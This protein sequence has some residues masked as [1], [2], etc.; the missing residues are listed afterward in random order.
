MRL[1]VS[2]RSVDEVSAALVGGA[3]VIDVKEPLRGALGAADPEVVKAIAAKVPSSIPVSVALG[4]PADAAV[5]QATVTRLAPHREAGEVILKLGFAGATTEI[6]T[7]KRL[8][9]AID[10]AS[11]G[12][13]PTLVAVAYADWQ[14]AGGPSP[15][16]VVRAA[17]RAGA[18]GV[19]L[20]TFIKERG[21]LFSS[22]SP[23][24]L[25]QWVEEARSLGLLVAVAGSLDAEGIVRLRSPLPDV[26]GIRG[27]ACDGG[28]LGR[29]S[30]E[31]VRALRLLV[32]AFEG[33]P[34]PGKPTANRQ[35]VASCSGP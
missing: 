12:T 10:L 31:R 5:V 26:V 35:T 23:R 6:E 24:A 3:D 25:P 13:A 27:A 33:R 9:A 28:R 22:I 34:D 7:E 20:D 21:N 18:R 29:V 19:L 30:G 15:S 1:L 17:A 32:D 8:S 11:S 16:A 2:V 14:H 4:D